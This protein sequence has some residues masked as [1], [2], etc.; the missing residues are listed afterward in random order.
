M[1][2]RI[3]TCRPHRLAVVALATLAVLVFPL[4]A[5]ANTTADTTI[6]NVVQVDYQDAGGLTSF[7]ATASSIVTVNLVASPLLASGPPTATTGD[8]GGAALTCPDTTGTYMVASGTTFES[9]FALTATANGNDFYGLVIGNTPTTA[10]N[11]AV[12]HQYYTYN[13]TDGFTLLAT[14]P[15][16]HELGAAVVVGFSGTDTLYFP[17]GALAGFAVNDIAV[18]DGIAYRVTNVTTGTAAVHANAGAVEHND[19]GSTTAEAQGSLTLA[20]LPVTDISINGANVAVGSGTVPAFNNSVIGLVIG[21]MVLVKISVTASAT[22]TT[23]SVAYTL[24]A[25]DS[26]DGAET[27]ACTV[28]FEG[29]GLTIRKDV[30][31]V[32]AGGTFGATTASGNPGDV[33]EYRV[34]VANTGGIATQVVV[35]DAVPAYTSLV[36]DAYDSGNAF[37]VITD[38]ADNTVNVTAAND[39]ETQPL[40]LV[41]TGYG[42]ATGSAAGSDL[43]FFLGNTATNAAGG[44]LPYCSDGTSLTV[45]A[46]TTAGK[47]WI[48]TLTIIY[49]V[50][51][52]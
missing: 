2:R 14:D 49:Q 26:G 39:G 18:I 15:A 16:D 20:A 13:G 5:L 1:N 9:L 24:T 41:E 7:T 28:N 43:T 42:E 44:T 23:G 32:N 35:T 25:T 38:N 31:N 40:D 27:I 4:A 11:V 46:C 33:L 17:G 50:T 30:R 19:E 37:A 10:G 48:D 47:E 36:A 29:V 51:I 45:A 3:S 22:A 34:T 52:D 12:S 21:E 8:E 6:L